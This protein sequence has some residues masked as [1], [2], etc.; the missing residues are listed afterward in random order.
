M[1]SV[2]ITILVILFAVLIYFMY[3]ETRK[4]EVN[5]IYLSDSHNALKVIHISD[6]HISLM[7]IPFDRIYGVIDSEKPD[8]ILFTGDY[9]DKEAHKHRF[10]EFIGGIKHQIALCLGNHDYHALSDN[11]EKV[12]GFINDLGAIGVAVLENRNMTLKK[13]GRIFNII[14][15]SDVRYSHQDVRAA[16]SGIRNEGGNTVNIVISHSPD[17]VMELVGRKVN[18]L[19]CGHFHGG[20]IRTFLNI[21]FLHMLQDNLW[22]KGY[23]CGFHNYKGIPMYINKGLGNTHLPLRLFAKPEITMIYF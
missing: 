15:I 7:N 16:F 18:C 5:R 19:L 3:L 23:I 10:L 2:I 6:V 8:I 13:A 9:I 20:Q 4:L 17:I 22:K 11:P 21:E 1:S 14:G 12:A